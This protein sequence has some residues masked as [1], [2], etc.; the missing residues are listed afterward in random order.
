[1]SLKKVKSKKVNPK[2]VLTE[3]RS[4]CDT[5]HDELSKK[6]VDFFSPSDSGGSLNINKNYLE[7]PSEITQVSSTDLGEYL[8]A[9]TQ[10]K[11]YLRTLLGYAEMY[12][13]EAR[14]QYM[15]CSEQ[16]YRNFLGSKLSE[17]AKEREVNTTPE[18][19]PSYE[20]WCDYKNKVKLL[21]YNI[22][23]IEDIIFMISREVSRRTGDFNE[24][25]R[26]YNVNRR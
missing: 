3:K 10:Q 25:N 12:A 19:R 4:Y 16:Q 6:G 15:S 8:N 7:L 21:N 17:T 22:S 1:M 18:V 9:F 20:K 24:E 14:L 2:E 11:A 5:V 26:N 23:S 13:E